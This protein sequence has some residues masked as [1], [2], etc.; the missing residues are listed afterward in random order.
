MCVLQALTYKT[1]RPKGR[2]QPNSSTFDIAPNESVNI[3]DLDSVA[4]E[5]EFLT[6]SD[7]QAMGDFD[8]QGLS[9]ESTVVEAQDAFNFKNLPKDVYG[10]LDE[11]WGNADIT[12]PLHSAQVGNDLGFAP[13]QP[14]RVSMIDS[15]QNG[16]RDSATA[17]I[18]PLQGPRDLSDSTMRIPEHLASNGILDETNMPSNRNPGRYA[19]DSSQSA[20]ISPRRPIKRQRLKSLLPF[21]K[22]RLA[23][24]GRAN[25]ECPGIPEKV[26][27]ATKSKCNDQVSTPMPTIPNLSHSKSLYKDISLQIIRTD[28]SAEWDRRRS[29]TTDL[30][31]AIVVKDIN[32]SD[33]DRRPLSWPRRDVLRKD[34]DLSYGALLRSKLKNCQIAD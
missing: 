16:L 26:P 32:I 27:A 7:G 25:I 12:A 13:V 5:F 30:N 23:K 1:L 2:E 28:R 34:L 14:P 3:F 4:M 29:R 11:P 18:P 19:T 10:A 24:N 17:Y 8:Q 21:E 33:S 22:K 20:D 15:D 6:E 31:D 9:S